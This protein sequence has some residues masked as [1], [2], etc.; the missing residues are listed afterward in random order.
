MT[1]EEKK[2]GVPPDSKSTEA[3]SKAPTMT[4][5]EKESSRLLEEFL[6]ENLRKAR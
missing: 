2:E 6:L 4:E 3:R 1:D 5:E